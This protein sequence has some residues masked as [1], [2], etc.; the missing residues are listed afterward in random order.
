[1]VTAGVSRFSSEPKILSTIFPYVKYPIIKT[2]KEIRKDAIKYNPLKVFYYT[3]II[4]LSRDLG[5]HLN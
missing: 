3:L 1:M 5:R 4:L 2:A